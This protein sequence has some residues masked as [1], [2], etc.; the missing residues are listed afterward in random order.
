GAFAGKHGDNALLVQEL[1]FR[2]GLDAGL[3]FIE[4]L[5]QFACAYVEIADQLM[6]IGESLVVAQQT[7]HDGFALKEAIAAHQIIA[8]I[9]VSDGTRW[10]V[11]NALFPHHS[12]DCA[13]RIAGRENRKQAPRF[14]RERSFLASGSPPG[15]ID[16]PPQ[17]TPPAS[18]RRLASKVLA[19]WPFEMSL[20]L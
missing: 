9:D 20:L 15:R 1:I 2:T 8:V 3:I 11:R 10:I 18:R 7:P 12:G 13:W 14:C 17:A 5:R 16:C 6:S 19:G 4:R